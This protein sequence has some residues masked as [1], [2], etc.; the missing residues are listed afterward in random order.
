ML[1]AQRI[2]YSSAAAQELLRLIF[3]AEFI[4]FF[5]IVCDGATALVGQSVKGLMTVNAMTEIR[6]GLNSVMLALLFSKKKNL[7]KFK[8]KL[9]RGSLS[10]TSGNA[11]ERMSASTAGRDKLFRCSSS[12]STVGYFSL[13]LWKAGCRGLVANFAGRSDPPSVFRLG[14]Y[15][16]IR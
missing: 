6:S 2:A 13:R 11:P 12:L 1:L 7:K 16:M 10:I 3:I 5:Y 4:G 8:L 9:E 15:D 14:A